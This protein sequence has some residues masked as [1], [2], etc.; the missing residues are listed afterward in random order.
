MYRI[1][2]S[3]V[4]AR[5]WPTKRWNQLYPSRD[6]SSVCPIVTQFETSLLQTRSSRFCPRY[7]LLVTRCLYRI[8][9]YAF[10]L[11]P[12][13][14]S[15]LKASLDGFM[16][17]GGIGKRIVECIPLLDLVDSFQRAYCGLC[18]FEGVNRLRL[19]INPNLVS[20]NIRL[21]NILNL[22]R[23]V[24]WSYSG[25]RTRVY[26]S[27][28]LL[29]WPTDRSTGKRVGDFEG[30]IDTLRYFERWDW[31]QLSAQHIK[32]SEC[33]SKRSPPDTRRH[34]TAW[35]NR[36]KRQRTYSV[37]IPTVILNVYTF[38]FETCPAV[39]KPKTRWILSVDW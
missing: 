10:P 3:D 22:I 19:D 2:V 23:I 17:N 15:F 11:H 32:V 34:V 29:N 24:G 31:D 26:V 28:G 25:R 39:A 8:F 5:S 27:S 4:Y 30:M 13:Q 12:L 9:C 21:G 14:F 7:R 35:S 6:K 1:Y 33:T 38:P 36:C 16:S 18:R 20:K 37:R